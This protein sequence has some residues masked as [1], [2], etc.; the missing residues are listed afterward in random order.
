MFFF[1]FLFYVNGAGGGWNT[2]TLDVLSKLYINNQRTGIVITFKQC[3]IILNLFIYDRH[4]PLSFTKLRIF[5]C[6][7]FF[8]SACSLTNTQTTIWWLRI[9]VTVS[10]EICLV[11]LPLNG[12]TERL[13]LLSSVLVNFYLWPFKILIHHIL[14]YWF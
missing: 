11:R 10:F 12:G 8:W 14:K 5:I 4:V 7:V 1:V 13:H 6:K 9:A 2:H 3:K